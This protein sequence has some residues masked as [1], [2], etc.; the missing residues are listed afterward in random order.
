MIRLVAP[1]ESAICGCKYIKK[2]LVASVFA[3]FGEY[4]SKM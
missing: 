3:P 1:L 2:F 4:F